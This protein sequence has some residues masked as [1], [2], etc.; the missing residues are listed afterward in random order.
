MKNGFEKCVK[1]ES[2]NFPDAAA[3]RPRP[4]H[5]HVKDYAQAELQTSTQTF[6]LSVP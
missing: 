4:R 1:F 2:P 6:R 5:K 3:E